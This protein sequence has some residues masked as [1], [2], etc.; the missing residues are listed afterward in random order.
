MFLKALNLN[1]Y[2][3]EPLLK[4]C[5]I[6]ISRNFT[7]VD[8]RVLQAPKVLMFSGFTSLYSLSMFCLCLL[9]GFHLLQLKAGNG[10]DFFARNGRWNF[11][12]KVFFCIKMYT[13]TR[14]PYFP[15]TINMPF[16]YDNVEI[17]GCHKDR[18]V[19]SG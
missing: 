3:A 15:I 9:S 16:S 10:E 12:N 14:Y 19:G 5:G 11:N 13:I 17:C 4:A 7:Q 1:N 2:D 18:E 8:G 6:S